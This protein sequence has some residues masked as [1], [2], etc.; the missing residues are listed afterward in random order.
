MDPN[1]LPDWAELF[2]T[3]VGTALADI[4]ILIGQRET[5][6]IRSRRFKS[7]LRRSYYNDRNRTTTC[8]QL[9]GLQCQIALTA[10]IET[11]GHSTGV[12]KR[13]ENW[14]RD[15]HPT[16]DARPPAP[17]ERSRQHVGSGTSSAT[18]RAG[19]S[20]CSKDEDWSRAKGLHGQAAGTSIA[21]NK[22]GRTPKIWSRRVSC[23]GQGNFRRPRVA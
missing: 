23:A 10:P 8:K 18:S 1:L 16:L 19:A 4:L 2:H 20:G 14:M 15:M 11:K 6:P 13:A 17:D 21:T 7:F 22:D 5:W 9:Q 12:S 3:V